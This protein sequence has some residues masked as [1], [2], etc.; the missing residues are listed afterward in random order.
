[1]NIIF[2]IIWLI[3]ITVCVYFYGWLTFA[4]YILDD[5]GENQFSIFN[6]ILPNLLTLVVLLIYTKEFLFGYHPKSN[7]QNGIS[8]VVMIVLILFLTFIQ[9]SQ[10]EFLFRGEELSNFIFI[11]VMA[12]ILTSYIGILLNR[13]LVVKSLNKTEMV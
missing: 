1:M 3:L 12:T 6:L 7:T 2:K 9:F 10:F 4:F 5:F 11:L 13:V 8:L